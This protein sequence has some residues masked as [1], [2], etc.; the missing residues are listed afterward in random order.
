M[1]KTPRKISIV[2]WGP[3]QGHH[4]LV[5]KIPFSKNNSKKV[6][7]SQRCNPQVID[8]IKTRIEP[9][10]LELLIGNESEFIKNLDGDNLIQDGVSMFSAIKSLKKVVIW[11]PSLANFTNEMFA[12]N[13]ELDIFKFQYYYKNDKCRRVKEPECRIAKPSS[14]VKANLILPNV[15]S[16]LTQSKPLPKIVLKDKDLK[17]RILRNGIRRQNCI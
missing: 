17:T 8:L 12:S 4:V 14:F 2:S 3:Y 15:S 16:F 9:F 5:S 11:A 6:Y 13:K 7:V 10:G 1:L